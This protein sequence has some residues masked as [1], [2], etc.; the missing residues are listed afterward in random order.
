[1]KLEIPPTTTNMGGN[2]SKSFD[3]GGVGDDGHSSIGPTMDVVTS[4]SSSAA[5]AAKDDSCSAMVIGN[6]KAEYCKLEEEKDRLKKE[7][8]SMQKLSEDSVY[9][10]PKPIMKILPSSSSSEPT[11]QSQH[12][13]NDED[14]HPNPA[15]EEDKDD[16]GD[17]D[18]Q[19]VESRDELLPQENQGTSDVERD[20]QSS[21]ATPYQES[22]MMDNY[23][24]ATSSPY[25][26]PPI[27]WANHVRSETSTSSSWSNNSIVSTPSRTSQEEN[28]PPYSPQPQ[29]YETQE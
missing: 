13:R 7:W 6:L 19:I 29:E 5:V 28:L 27:T 15:D 10:T 14:K 18:L 23:Y 1:M 25:S 24:S 2:G 8:E 21:S 3:D 26:P 9:T 12:T 20:D 11:T 17:E 16:D 22:R 4:S